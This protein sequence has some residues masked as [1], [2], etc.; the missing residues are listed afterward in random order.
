MPKQNS[1][2]KHILGQVIQVSGGQVGRDCE[3]R[4][5][6]DCQR[7]RGWVRAAASLR[8]PPVYVDA[9]VCSGSLGLLQL[10]LENTALALLEGMSE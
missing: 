10:G 5:S 8:L 7:E 4:K 2:T 9:A 1:A 6:G 3:K